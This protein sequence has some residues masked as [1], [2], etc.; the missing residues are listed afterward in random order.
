MYADTRSTFEDFVSMVPFKVGKR[1]SLEAREARGIP[2][3]HDVESP[4]AA[5]VYGETDFDTIALGLAT[6]QHKFGVDLRGCTFYDIGCGTGRPVFAAALLYPRWSKCVGIEILPEL[7]S[8]ARDELQEQ[9]HDGMPYLPKGSK[10]TVYR[11]GREARGVPLH[12]VEADAADVTACVDEEGTVHDWGADADVVYVCSTCFDKGTMA[13]L[14][15]VAARMKQGSWFL[16][17]GTHLEEVEGWKLVDSIECTFSWGAG[18]L[19]LCRKQ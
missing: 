11:I 3:E 7:L 19:F 17:S 1:L 9:W 14:Q 5:L 10:A 12:W 18:T 6:I 2:Q 4:F 8:V 15:A 16:S 13:K